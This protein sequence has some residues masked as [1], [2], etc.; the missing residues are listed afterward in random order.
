MST[1]ENVDI[2]AT[3]DTNAALSALQS[4]N[5]NLE[6]LVTTGQ[7][8]QQSMDGMF[9]KGV[10]GATTMIASVAGVTTAMQ[11]MSLATRAAIATYD[12]WQQRQK[13]AADTQVTFADAQRRFG[14]V[15]GAG[16]TLDAAT[17]RV[18]SIAQR[19]GTKAETVGLALEQALSAKGPALDDESAFAAVSE[20]AEYRPGSSVQEIGS[21]S[22]ALLSMKKADPRLNTR[23]SMAYIRSALR[24]ARNTDI[25]SFATYN[26]PAIAQAKG[27][28]DGSDSF[29]EL[30]SFFIGIGQ[31]ADDPSGRRTATGGINF[32]K[33][34]KLATS[35]A[36]GNNASVKSQ[37]DYLFNTEAGTDIRKNLL[38]PLFGSDEGIEQG[39][40][41]ASDLARKLIGRDVDLKSEA[42]LFIPLVQFLRGG[43]NTTWDNIRAAQRDVRNEFDPRA[44]ADFN[45]A[46][47]AIRQ[48]PLQRAAQTRRAL[49]NARQ[50]L[51][52]DNDNPVAG[53][54]QDYLDTLQAAG[55]R[56]DVRAT[57]GWDLDWNSGDDRSTL[58]TMRSQTLGRTNRWRSSQ[59]AEFT[60]NAPGIES[61]FEL[62]IQ[63]IDEQLELMRKPQEVKLD[64]GGGPAD[65]GQMGAAERAG[66]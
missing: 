65:R 22:Q 62:L 11:A 30:G 3:A 55:V 29:A 41:F 36:L 14:N 16:T 45:A 57:E 40:D 60:P 54:K 28:G 17:R 46:E 8:T 48:H 43:K 27:F 19:T 26:L 15:L 49:A 25:E 6:R 42:K 33:Q 1:T 56:W 7:K 31:T 39:S 53:L 24:A 10:L 63:K 59:G 5:A 37:F 21:I 51:E 47:R 18:Q 61:Q 35:D 4:I 52:L 32:L 38:G 13:K 20:A 9:E 44:V 58:E 50:G 2:R 64:I 34:I 23:Q 12:D 66:Q